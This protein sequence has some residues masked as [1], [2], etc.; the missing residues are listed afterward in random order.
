VKMF[1]NDARAA[2]FT[3]EVHAPAIH[4]TVPATSVNPK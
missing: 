2:N 1:V 4:S 3:L